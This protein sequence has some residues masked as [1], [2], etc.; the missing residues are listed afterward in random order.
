MDLLQIAGGDF[1]TH[2][3][4][5]VGNPFI[6]A[7]PR[8][9]AVDEAQRDILATYR[10]GNWDAALHKLAA[11]RDLKGANPSLYDLYEARIAR[12]TATP[13][14]PGWNGAEPVFL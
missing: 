3:Y 9:R 7:S 11:A 4:A 10:A 5:L 6:K 1:A 13:P 14:G 12:F 8:Y 2:V